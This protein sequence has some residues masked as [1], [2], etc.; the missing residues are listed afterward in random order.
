MRRLDEAKKLLQQN[1]LVKQNDFDT[2]ASLALIAVYECN[3]QIAIEMGEKALA[4]NPDQPEVH[5]SVGY[6][7]LMAGDFKRGFSG[8]E[9][10]IGKSR[11]R[12]LDPP[13]D[14]CPYWQGE[15]GIDLCVRGEQGIGDEI[16]FASV[17]PEIIP[18][19][20]SVTLDAHHKLAGLLK[21]SFPGI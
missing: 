20:K 1:R 8:F 16:S 10:F 9:K 14:L 21:R 6:A 4:L 2:L 12:P 19:M 15:D 7:Y 5:E 18:R 13:N 17:L 11:F 3:P